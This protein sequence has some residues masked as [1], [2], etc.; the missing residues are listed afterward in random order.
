MHLQE[1]SNLN[2]WTLGPK[3]DVLC[4]IKFEPKIDVHWSYWPIS[5]RKISLLMWLQVM[6]HWFLNKIL[7]L[8]GKERSGTLWDQKKSRMNKS[9]IKSRL[10]LTERELSTKNLFIQ[11][12]LWSFFD[13]EVL[14]RLRKRFFR[15][16]LDF[17]RQ[18]DA[19]SWHFPKS[20][21][22]LSHIFFDLESISVVSMTFTVSLNWTFTLKNVISGL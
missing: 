2:L 18:M 19:P 5:V 13:K 7:K 16:R 3:I 9:K 12:K 1:T 8:R 21:C 20:H 10:I 6:N 15:V 22:P 14:E 11:D 17:C 4:Y